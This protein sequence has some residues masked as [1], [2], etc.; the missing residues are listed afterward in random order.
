MVTEQAP[1]PVQSPVQPV[2]VEP[3]RP[4]A[5]S[6]TTCPAA[7]V[8]VQVAPQ[9]TPAGELV[10]VPVPVP[11]LATV[12]EYVGAAAKVA[13]TDCALLIVTT[14]APVLPQPPPLHS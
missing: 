11:V 4:A 6:V 14:Q 10:T 9:L 2:K 3:A 8:Y 1:V 13:V 12:S 5:A 7:K